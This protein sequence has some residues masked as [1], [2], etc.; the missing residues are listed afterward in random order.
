M[1]KP[2][3]RVLIEESKWDVHRVPIFRAS[4]RG[5][6]VPL[7]KTLLTNACRY[8]C[9]Y[10][11]F[12]R[13][14]SGERVSWKPEELVDVTLK[15]WSKGVIKGLFLSSS[16]GGDPDYIVEKQV[17][18]VEALRSRGFNGYVHLRLMPGTSKDLVWRAASVADRI[19]VNIEAPD[20]NF[21][22]EIA[23]DKGDFKNDILKRLEWCIRAE[24]HLKNSRRLISGIKW[25]R[26]RSGVDTQVIVG[27]WGDTDIQHLKITEELYR[28]GL[29]RV[30]Y[31]G[32]QPV[33]DTPLEV[34]PET[35]KSRVYRLYQ[36]SFL[37]RDYGF[38]TEMLENILERGY[39]P[40]KNPKIAFAEA[41]RDLYP[42]SLEDA[43]YH[44][45]LLVPGIGPKSAS[46]IIEER[47]VKKL[48]VED[49]V[50][51]LGVKRSRLALRYL[52]V[53]SYKIF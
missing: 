12:R 23:P 3:W 8:S 30:Y 36:A 38:T 33:L 47:S 19:G 15:L 51:I 7:L 14:K 44:E 21:F 32:F 52:E 25:G 34:F 11:P 41:N 29:K 1:P 42:I 18:I 39:L 48:R 27:S 50:R 22:E 31:S 49:I 4:S 2:K 10:C 28:L 6:T 35:K 13:E 24:E 53:S 16:V 26:L 20:K 46:R 37:I 40:D 9:L 5:K 43:S 17:E 45:L